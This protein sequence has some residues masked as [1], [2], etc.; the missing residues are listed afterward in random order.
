MKGR[1]PLSRG[2]SQLHHQTVNI[3]ACKNRNT[4]E[5][6][7]SWP[8]WSTVNI[9]FTKT[10]PAKSP[11]LSLY[12]QHHL[13]TDLGC[14]TF[15][16]E[17]NYF[18]NTNQLLLLLIILTPNNDHLCNYHLCITS[19]S[20]RNHVINFVLKN[21]ISI[22]GFDIGNHYIDASPD[23]ATSNCFFP[24]GPK[25]FCCS[26]FLLLCGELRSV[27]CMWMYS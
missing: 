23:P 2:L 10:F 19:V 26:T 27:L 25:L 15:R 8:W 16:N 14:K 12:S 17:R 20:C 5:E 18:C 9:K 3:S 6:E 13:R 11:R 22:P 1:Q 21:Y 4:E 7:R 24:G